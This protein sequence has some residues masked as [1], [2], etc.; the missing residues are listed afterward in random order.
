MALATYD[1]AAPKKPVNLTVNADLLS[2]ARQLGVNLSDAL[3]T[4]L[5]ELVAADERER[6]RAANR[7]AIEEYN[8]R[9]ENGPLL[10]D[11]TRTF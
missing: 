1:K 5:A 3:E 6:W 10:S 9:I 11:F 4:R 2:R 8:Q 7:E